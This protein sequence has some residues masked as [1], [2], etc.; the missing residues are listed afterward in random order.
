MIWLYLAQAVSQAPEEIEDIRSP[1]T[2][3]PSLMTTGILACLLVIVLVAYF[4]WPNAKPRAVLPPLPKDV[5]RKQLEAL[6]RGIQMENGYA[7]SIKISDLL[8]S[9]IEQ[10]FGIKAVRQTTNEFLIEASRNSHFDLAQQERL[11]H[12][13]LTCDSIKFAQAN[14]GVQENEALFEEAVAFVEEAK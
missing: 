6:K 5:A 10:N 12:F 13:L 7:F 14:A 3:S 11:R 4:A 9:F 8:R 1:I 2:D